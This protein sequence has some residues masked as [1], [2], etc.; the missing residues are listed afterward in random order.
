MS[1]SIP[2]TCE[3]PGPVDAVVWD[4]GNV[5][6]R[7]DPAAAFVERWPREQFETMA[8]RSGFWALNDNMDRATSNEE[9][10]EE[11]AS[12]D[13]EAAEFWRHYESHMPSSL[14]ADIE[15][16]A[17]LVHELA[18]AGVPQYG[19]TNWNSTLA[20][21]IP[22]V[23]P[24]STRLQGYVVSAL[25]QQVKPDAAI[26]HTLIERFGLVPER[27]LFIDDREENTAAAAALGFQV[28]TFATPHGAPEL[29]AHI[30][31]LG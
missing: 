23:V 3:T 28:H 31:Q 7:W 27:T 4:F 29:R 14:F 8:E 18:D 30:A 19:L 24:G 11:L 16:T 5:L 21:K 20:P 10:L 25:E 17:E 9:L 13:P 15:G 12:R 26:F 6:V 1:R 22:E 2:S